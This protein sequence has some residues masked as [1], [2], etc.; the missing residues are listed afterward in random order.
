MQCGEKEEMRVHWIH[1]GSLK[2]VTGIELK[3][4]FVK[5]GGKKDRR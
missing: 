3:I 2:E 4:G 1:W 5:I